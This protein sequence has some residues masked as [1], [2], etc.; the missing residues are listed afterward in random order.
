MGKFSGPFSVTELSGSL[1]EGRQEVTTA[2]VLTY[3][4]DDN[5]IISVPKGFITDFAS[6][7]F[8]L[9][10]LIPSFGPWAKAAIIH[11]YLYATAGLRRGLSRAWCDRVFL[12]ALKACG[13]SLWRRNAMWAAVRLGGS[14]GWGG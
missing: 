10:G 3:I 2:D 13:V 6:V 14:G 8:W 5:T 9:D 11:D 4:T 7:P 1:R 12:E